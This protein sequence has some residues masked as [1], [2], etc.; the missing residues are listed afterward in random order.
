M[1]NPAS[2]TGQPQKRRRNRVPISCRA[3]QVRKLKCNRQRPCQNCEVRGDT[4]DCVYAIRVD[5]RISKLSASTG[6]HEMQERIDKLEELVLIAL[7]ASKPPPTQSAI[8]RSG[9]ERASPVSNNPQS[10]NH[11]A[12]P[13][14]GIL[15]TDSRDRHLYSGETAWNTVL[16]EVS[17]PGLSHQQSLILSKSSLTDGHVQRSATS[18]QLAQKALGAEPTSMR[19]PTKSESNVLHQPTFMQEVQ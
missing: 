3:C 5:D 15:E 13:D 11:S 19:H 18:G 7:A 14:I 12:N 6:R 9:D 1:Q 16:Y 10:S 17:T 2:D 4:D 8:N